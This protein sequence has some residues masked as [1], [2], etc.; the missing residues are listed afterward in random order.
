MAREIGVVFVKWP[1]WARSDEGKMLAVMTNDQTLEHDLELAAARLLI[2]LRKPLFNLPELLDPKDL[3][4][5]TYFTECHIRPTHRGDW[6]KQWW[7]RPGEYRLT[8]RLCL[9]HAIVTPTGEWH[10]INEWNR[11]GHG[12]RRTVV[13][14]LAVKNYFLDYS[15]LP[16]VAFDY[17]EDS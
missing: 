8:E 12:D 17:C 6:L 4:R 14:E 10:D 16:V 15:D 9:P 13:W 3:S 11:Y 2:P 1:K 7:Y 5:P